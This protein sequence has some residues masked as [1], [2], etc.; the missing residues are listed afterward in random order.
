MNGHLIDKKKILESLIEKLNNELVEVSGAAKSARDLATADDLKSEGKYDTRAIEASYLA[1]AQNKRVEEIKLD[2]Q[3]L[4]DLQTQ[5]DKSTKLQLGSLGL[6]SCNGQARLYFLSSTSGGSMIM[7]DGNP[8][9]VISVFSPIG[10]AALGLG[11]GESFEVETPK[12]TRSYDVLE[13]Y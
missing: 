7:I 4:E 3:M 11:P 12:E 10:D 13:V 6:I 8:I 9:L 5:I 2:I 1:S